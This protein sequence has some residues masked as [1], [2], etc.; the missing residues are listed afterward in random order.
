MIH[1]QLRRGC[2]VCIGDGIQGIAW[3]WNQAFSDAING[4]GLKDILRLVI[5]NKTLKVL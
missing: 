2:D 1:T 3:A 4:I 5:K